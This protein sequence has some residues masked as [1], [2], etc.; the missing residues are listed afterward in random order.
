VVLQEFHFEALGG[1][2]SDYQV[3]ALISPHLVNAG[4]AAAATAAAKSVLDYMITVQE[5]DG[6]LWTERGKWE[7]N[8]FIVVIGE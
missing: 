2:P 3:H 5:A 6:Q 7:G 4:L 1:K 8:D